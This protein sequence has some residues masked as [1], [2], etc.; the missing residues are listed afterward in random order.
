MSGKIRK[1]PNHNGF[2]EMDIVSSDSTDYRDG[3]DDAYYWGLTMT[4]KNNGEFIAGDTKGL[5]CTLTGDLDF[6][7]GYEYLIWKS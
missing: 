6:F 4:D 7:I 3:Y 2:C 5:A 1:A